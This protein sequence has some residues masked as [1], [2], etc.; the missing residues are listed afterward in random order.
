[1]SSLKPFRTLEEQADIIL[2]RGCVGEKADII[3]RLRFVNYY[4]FSGYLYP[5]RQEDPTSLKKLEKFVPGT[6][7]N[8]VWNTYRFDRRLR[9]LLLDAIERIE[10]ALRTRVAYLWSESTKNESGVYVSNPQISP[11]MLQRSFYSEFLK[12]VQ[13]NYDISSADCAVH[14]KMN[15]FKNVKDLPIWVFVEFMTFGNFRPLIDNGLSGSVKN[16]LAKS[17]NLKNSKKLSSIVSL[18]REVRNACA[19]HSRVWNRS[20]SYKPKASVVPMP[21]A[22]VIPDCPGFAFSSV[23]R[24]KTGYFLLLCDFLLQ[25][26]APQSL[27]KSRLRVLYE[28]IRIDPVQMGFRSEEDFNA[29]VDV[30]L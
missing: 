14:H 22:P 4:R 6:N 1:M 26:I 8:D 16:A 27:W 21:I 12:A 9:I 18:I 29:W 24:N 7:F 15:G 23:S 17:F 28:E 3:E 11:E 5:Y 19:H 25:T 2:S 10:V 20:W 13:K 30:S